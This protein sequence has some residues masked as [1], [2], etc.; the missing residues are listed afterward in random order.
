[1][2]T[3][4]TRATFARLRASK[5]SSSARRAAAST[6]RS[7]LSPGAVLATC[8]MA[9]PLHEGEHR[10]RRRLGPL[11]VR[12]MPTIGDHHGLR[13]RAGERGPHR[14]RLLTTRPLQPL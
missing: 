3:P 9:D 13:L 6:T 10:R 11:R 8:D 4:N 7:R 2:A 12:I 14:L 5:P 1:T